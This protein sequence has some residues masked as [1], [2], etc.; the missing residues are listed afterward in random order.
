MN[1]DSKYK[2]VILEKLRYIINSIC[3]N[4]QF[5]K[6]IE[7]ME[8]IKLQ[9]TKKSYTKVIVFG[10]VI[11][12]VTELVNL[13]PNNDILGLSFIA[14]TFGFWIFTTTFIIYLS[15]SNKN[16]MINTFLYLASMCF[17]FYLLQGIIT[18]FTPNITVDGLIEWSHLFFWTIISIICGIVAYILYYWNKNNMF[19]DILYALPIAGMLIDT[20]NNCLKFY[21]SHTQLLGAILDI[22]FLIIMFCFFMKKT[23]R[24]IIFIITVILVAI[25]GNF[26]VFPKSYNLTT[27]ATIVCELDGKEEIFYIKIK[28]D[29]EIIEKKGNEKIYKEIDI[30]SLKSVPEVVHALQNYYESK[31]GTCI[32]SK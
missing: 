25:I 11:G 23:N 18:F 3:A 26:T 17:S 32:T 27:E 16:A 4:L 30:N 21:Y 5:M 10:L 15:C 24:K 28:D 1:T 12:I 19:S 6:G 8:K 2:K 29:G 31:G 14:G 20:V 22:I 9:D 13:L 7:K